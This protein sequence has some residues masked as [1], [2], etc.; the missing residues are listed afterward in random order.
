MIDDSDV[1]SGE[2]FTIII[3]ISFLLIHDHNVLVLNLINR[4]RKSSVAH[5]NFNLS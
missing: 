5:K 2:S 1:S 4:Y 3:I